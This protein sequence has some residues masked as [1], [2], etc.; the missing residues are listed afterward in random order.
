MITQLTIR[1]SGNDWVDI[2]NN[3]F[4]ITSIDLSRFADAP[5]LLGDATIFTMGTP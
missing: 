2:Y 3:M 5:L 1:A 4:S